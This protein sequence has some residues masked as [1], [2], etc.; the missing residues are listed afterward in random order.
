MSIALRDSPIVRTNYRLTG[1]ET[2]SVSGVVAQ[3]SYSSSAAA[4]VINVS[5][6]LN[7][8]P[9]T[10]FANLVI[11]TAGANGARH[12]HLVGIGATYLTF[13]VNSAD[14]DACLAGSDITLVWRAYL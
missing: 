9:R 2:L 8:T 7:G 3:G 4:G 1:H 11:A 5:H 13:L 12:V 6:G 14:G 10:A